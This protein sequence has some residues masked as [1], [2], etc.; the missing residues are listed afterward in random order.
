MATSG[1]GPTALATPANA[2]TLVRVLATPLLIAIIVDEGT[3]WVPFTMW[4][5]L[6]VTDCADGWLARRQGTTRSGA[7]LDPLADKVV[8]LGAMAALVFIER[9]WWF[10]VA[11]IAARELAVSAYRSYVGRRGVSVPARPWAKVKTLFQDVAVGLALMPI[12][13]RGWQ[14]VVGAFLWISV[15]L[16]LVTGAQYLADGRRVIRAV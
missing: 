15:A 11:L 13:G 7:F 1:Y 5:V 9:M 10:P 16:T 4:T 2:L 12:A 6:A 14:A 8:V 3:G